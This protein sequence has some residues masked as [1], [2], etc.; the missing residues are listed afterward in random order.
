VKMFWIFVGKKNNEKNIPNHLLHIIC[1]RACLH[2][3]WFYTFNLYNISI[4]ISISMIIPVYILL[5][6]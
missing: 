6:P 4:G 2:V 3:Y 1:V 5:I